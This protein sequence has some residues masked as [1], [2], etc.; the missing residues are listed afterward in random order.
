M[1]IIEIL[2]PEL[3]GI[4]GDKMNMKYLSKCSSEFKFIETNHKDVPYF[5]DNTVDM[6]YIGPMTEDK[7]EMFIKYLMPY[8]DKIKALIEKQVVFFVTGNALEI[9]GQYIIDGD[10]K[11]ECLNIFDYYAKRDTSDVFNYQGIGKFNEFEVIIHKVQ[12]SACY[13]KFKYPFIT[14]NSGF[15]MNENYANEGICYKN[16]FGTYSLGPFLITNP[17]FTQYLLNIL[18]IKDEIA[19]KDDIIDAYKDR[20][21]KMRE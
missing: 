8:K 1:K 5:V 16:F 18:G 15:G 12:F 14:K 19:Y 21:S 3:C 7:Q 6:I 17:L 2:Y 9:F 10:R 4:Y 20:L 11:I 13:G